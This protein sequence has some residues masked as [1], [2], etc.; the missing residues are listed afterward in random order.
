MPGKTLSPTFNTNLENLDSVLVA[1]ARP[2]TLP[3]PKQMNS[4]NRPK[5]YE[6][7]F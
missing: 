1:W 7:D 3:L 6:I 2:A 5:V 4:V